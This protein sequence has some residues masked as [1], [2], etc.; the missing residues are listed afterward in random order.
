MGFGGNCCCDGKDP[1]SCMMCVKGPW[2][3]PEIVALLDT[4]PLEHLMTR[5]G[6]RLLIEMGKQNLPSNFCNGEVH[7]GQNTVR[8]MDVSPLSQADEK[9]CEARAPLSEKWHSNA[10]EHRKSP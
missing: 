1:M 4:E 3:D 10:C 9:S 7:E 5:E 8:D 6:C 2:I